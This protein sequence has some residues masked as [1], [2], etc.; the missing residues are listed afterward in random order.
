MNLF[1]SLQAFRDVVEAGGFAAAGRHRGVSRAVINKQVQQLENYLGTQ[2]LRRSTRVVTPTETGQ[3]FY[4]KC[5]FL[6]DELE[7]TISDIGTTQTALKGNLRI[8]APMSFGAKYLAP[9]I[10]AFMQAHPD[11]HVELSL[12]DRF[13]DLI[14]EG[15]DLTVRIAEPD[16]LTSIVTERIAQTDR[17]LCAGADFAVAHPLE[18]PRDLRSVR[19][20]HYGLQQSGLR[21]QLDGPEGRI[22]TRVHCVM[23]SNNGDVLREA[24][25]RDQGVAMLPMYL[26]G[27]DLQEGRLQRVLL[28]YAMSPLDISVLYPRHR[29]LSDKVRTLAEFIK[30]AFIGT[31][32]WGLVD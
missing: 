20:L 5:C 30:T 21:W 4:Q 3:A 32:S 19:C 18:H 31:P 8:N 22:S 27:D 10:A 24:A 17:I 16:H 15:F 25:V 29:H 26:I 12:S 11:I 6:L 14:E 13:V 23:W 2:L 7:T 28:E 1:S 9:V